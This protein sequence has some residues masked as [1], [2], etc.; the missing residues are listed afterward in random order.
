MN[1]M[2]YEEFREKNP[3]FQS[4]I[5]AFTS[6]LLSPDPKGIVLWSMDPERAYTEKSFMIKFVVFVVL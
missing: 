2:K 3:D 6:G 5:E 4:R 1:S